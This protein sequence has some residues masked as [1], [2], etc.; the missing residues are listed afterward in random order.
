[1]RTIFLVKCHMHLRND[2][3]HIIY[4]NESPPFNLQ[5]LGSLRFVPMNK[6]TLLIWRIVASISVGLPN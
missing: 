3:Q 4:S 1:M 6:I 2:V 5:V